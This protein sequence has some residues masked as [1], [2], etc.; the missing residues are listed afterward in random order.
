VRERLHDIAAPYHI[1]ANHVVF[2][3]R[4]A[5]LTVRRNP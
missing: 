3:Y 4:F 5:C 2:G 1:D